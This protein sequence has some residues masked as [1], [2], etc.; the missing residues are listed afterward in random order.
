M[1]ILKTDMLHRPTHNLTF[2]QSKHV[3][4]N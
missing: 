3:I 1:E 2:L 4:K